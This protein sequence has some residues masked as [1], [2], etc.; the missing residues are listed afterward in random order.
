MWLA[1]LNTLLYKNQ[2]IPIYNYEKELEK[3]KINGI[4]SK[5]QCRPALPDLIF[6][7]NCFAKLLILMAT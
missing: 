4:N 7:T 3:N 2:I 1:T 5:K 6:L